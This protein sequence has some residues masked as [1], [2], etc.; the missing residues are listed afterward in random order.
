MHPDE[1][2]QNVIVTGCSNKRAVQWEANTCEIV[3]EYDEHMGAVNT[4]T[5]C[6]DGKRADAK[7][8]N[9]SCL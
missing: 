1:S 6:E 8:R 3:Q 7:G 5:I 9:I 2:K 4:V